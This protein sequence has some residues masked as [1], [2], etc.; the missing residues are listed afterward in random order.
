V[1]GETGTG[2]ELVAKAVHDLSPRFDKAFVPFNSAAVQDEL[3]ESELFGHAKG[4]FT[5]A[6]TDRAGRV[7]AAEGG[8]LFLDEVA[9]LSS[10]GQARLLRFLESREYS[11]VGE[12]RV[13]KA[14]VRIVV[15]TNV[16]LERR[17]EEGRFREDL[18]HRMMDPE[19]T[20]PPLRERGDDLL[21]LAGHFLT[22]F[23][24]TSGRPR[25]RLSA[26]VVNLLRRF[27]WPGNVREL[28]SVLESA[29]ALAGPDPLETVHLHR[30]IR[31]AGPAANL[32]GDIE[33]SRE[34]ER[35][36]RTLDATGGNCTR[37]AAK[38]GVTRQW[39]YR[40]RKRH[41]LLQ[42]ERPP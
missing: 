34:R 41:G 25:Q 32:A 42:G 17:V 35:I 27:H 24:A 14:N 37:A 26:S 40:M 3:F 36:E 12:T 39:F 8:T 38:L 7:Q 20:L 9:E 31:A 30:R 11:R 1:I 21:V 6:V 16:D 28:R 22:G 4:A 2:K 33:I 23:A 29:V 15:A 10:R 13:R 5:G 19:V 18:L